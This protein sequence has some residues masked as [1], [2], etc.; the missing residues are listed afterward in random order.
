MTILA[1]GRGRSIDFNA[2]IERGRIHGSLYFDPDVFAQEMEKIFHRG[3]VFLAHESELPKPGDFVRRLL[4]LQ[5]VIVTRGKE[6]E[7]NVLFNRCPHRGAVVCQQERGHRR[8][9]TCPY[10][11]WS[12]AMDGSLVGLPSAD[13]YPQSFDKAQ[14]GLARA[15]RVDS[16]GGF[17]FASLAEDGI[18]LDEHL[19]KAKEWIVQLLEL[20][21]ERE[22][23]LTAGWMK[24]RLNCNWKMVVENQVDGYHA[25]A[26]HGS[27]IA[28]NEIFAT[29]R[30]RKDTSPTRVRDFGMGH[31]DIDHASDYRAAGDKLFRWAGGVSPDRFPGYVDAMKGR[32]GEE[33]ATRRLI[34][35]PAH[36]MLFPNISLAEM[37]IMVIQPIS[38]TE[39]V[40]YTTP[41][42]LKGAGDFN[43][44]TMRRCEGA[45]GPAGF[46]IADDA[47]IGELTQ[48][49]VQNREPEWIELSRGLEQEEVRPDG[50]RIAGLMDETSQRGFWRH[51]RKIMSGEER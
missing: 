46:L 39:T 15:P 36:A 17:I 25:P 1:E 31:T 7:V 40:Q 29:V 6:G 44:R 32:Y 5:S 4:G 41:V 19:G 43:Q 38:P 34:D 22:I 11:G 13:A 20:S 50:T 2:L 8:M 12:F 51:Y 27:L 16:C 37:N 9:L 18:S 23:Q 30:D 49:G 48:M 21:P 24:H 26:V 42:L 47:E 10:H 3:W 45:L 33:G 28:A 14:A 35:G